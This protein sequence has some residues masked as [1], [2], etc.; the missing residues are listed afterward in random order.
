ML[1]RSVSYQRDESELL[2]VVTARLARPLAPH[3]VPPLPTD[4]ELNDPGDIELFLFGGQNRRPG[5]K[6][7][8]E[9]PPTEVTTE[10]ASLDRARGPSGELGF[11]R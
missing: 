6:P 8:E 11:I 10:R 3:E 9:A 2:V 1:F 7:K 5:S 4:D